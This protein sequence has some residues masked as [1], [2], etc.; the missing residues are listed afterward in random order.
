M[1][2][3]ALDFNNAGITRLATGL[4]QQVIDTATKRAVRKTAVWM[5]GV[6]AK[7]ASATTQLPKRILASRI[8]LYKKGDGHAMKVWLGANPV[9][10]DTIATPRKLAQGYAVGKHTFPNAFMPQSGRYAGKLY[11]R[12]TAKRLPIQRVKV[13]IENEG[14]AA[15]DAAALQVEARFLEIMRHEINYEISKVMDSGR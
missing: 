1:I 13:E 9:I 11:Q 6:M 4:S 15:F 3:L 2:T 14:K 12:T 10:A 5:R 8:Q 7:N